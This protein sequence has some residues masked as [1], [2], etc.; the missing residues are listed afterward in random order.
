VLLIAFGPS[1]LNF[2]IR[3]WTHDFENW[4]GIRSSL[5]T[6]IHAALVEAGVGIPFPQQDLHLRSVSTDVAAALAPRGAA[7]AE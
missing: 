2:S 5:M 6:R 4:R 7:P 3:A 1:S